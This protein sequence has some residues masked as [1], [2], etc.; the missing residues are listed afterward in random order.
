MAVREALLELAPRQRAVLVLRYFED[1]PP[2]QVV[3]TPASARSSSAAETKLVLQAAPQSEE[4]SAVRV[5]QGGGKV[6]Q[7]GT[8]ADGREVGEVE[9]GARWLVVRLPAG[10]Q[11]W[12]DEVLQRFMASC[13]LS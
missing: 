3:L 11:G 7:L 2:G 5:I 13:R 12:S 9:L 1:L 6:F 10:D 8:V 4:L